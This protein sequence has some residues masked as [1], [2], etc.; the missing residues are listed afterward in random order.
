M[1]NKLF[2]P[3]MA[4]VVAIGMSFATE[5]STADPDMDYYFENG[6]FHELGAEVPCVVGEDICT[7][8]RVPGGPIYDVYD[9]D[10]PGTKK[11][12]GSD[13]INLWEILN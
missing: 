3:G 11:V 1:K 2:L 13:T 4:M 12:G 6:E 8:R 5:R 7:V 9:A 10:D